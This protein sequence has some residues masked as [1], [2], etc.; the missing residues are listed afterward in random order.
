MAE[1]KKL[2][3]PPIKASEID[4]ESA[5]SGQVLTANGTGGASWQNASGGGTQL[6]MHA[7]SLHRD[8]SSSGVFGSITVYIINEI[9]AAYT[10]ISQVAFTKTPVSG[11]IF[12]DGKLSVAGLATKD[13]GSNRIS[14]YYRTM[15]NLTTGAYA[16]GGGWTT[17]TADGWSADYVTK[18]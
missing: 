5:T 16:G 4:S 3:N 9:Q 14:V 8:S 1:F 7:I 17:L 11:I 15:W 2:I 13:S 18:L 6:Y 10:S 12:E